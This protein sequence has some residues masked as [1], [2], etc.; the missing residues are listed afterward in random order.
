MLKESEHTAHDIEHVSNQ[1][2]KRSDVASV[3]ENEK[4]RKAKRGKDQRQRR[5]EAL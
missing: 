5:R 1:L 4:K 2:K 3:N